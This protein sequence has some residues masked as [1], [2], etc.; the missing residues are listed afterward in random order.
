[1][2]TRNAASTATAT[3]CLDEPEDISLPVTVADYIVEVAT[4]A[5]S[6]VSDYRDSIVVGNSAGG[7]WRGDESSALDLASS[8]AAIEGLKE[9]VREFAGETSDCAL[10]GT[11][12]TPEATESLIAKILGKETEVVGRLRFQSIAEHNHVPT[13]TLPVDPEAIGLAKLRAKD[14]ARG[15]TDRKWS[16]DIDPEGSYDI[17]HI[18][19]FVNAYGVLADAADAVD[20]PALREHLSKLQRTLI[21]GFFS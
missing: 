16:F 7:L 19:D 3:P 1:M 12:T 6:V 21:D 15:E 13:E 8:V 5:Q 14:K 11:D 2:N 20:S 18:P 10:V 4:N 17:R 9:I